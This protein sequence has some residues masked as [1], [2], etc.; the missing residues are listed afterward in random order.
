MNTGIRR[1]GLSVGLTFALAVALLGGPAGTAGAAQSSVADRPT[2][3]VVLDTAVGNLPDV[4]P[5]TV[6]SAPNEAELQDLATIAEQEGI[7][8]DQAIAR[9]AWN[10]NFTITLDEIR[11]GQR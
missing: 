3:A 10:D 1:A 9:Y 11:A 5:A 7:T 4:A 2:P 8:L 6:E